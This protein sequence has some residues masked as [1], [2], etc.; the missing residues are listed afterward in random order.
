MKTKA[1]LVAYI[2]MLTPVVGLASIK[3]YINK[4]AEQGVVIEHLDVPETA[5]LIVDRD[6]KVVAL[7]RVEPD[8]NTSLINIEASDENFGYEVSKSV[9]NWEFEPKAEPYLVKI[10]FI[11]S[12]NK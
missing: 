12:N 11:V 2:I 4:S 8:G 10:P 9:Q 7:V 6:E 1:Q 5:H 3:D